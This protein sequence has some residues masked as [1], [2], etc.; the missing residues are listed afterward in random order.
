MKRYL[1]FL[2]LAILTAGVSSGQSRETRDLSGFTG[3]NFGVAGTVIIEQGSTFSVILEGDR[4][5]LEEIQ[6][7]IRGSSLNIR[8][9]NGIW[10]RNTDKI[11]VY[12]TMPE[13]EGLSVSGSGKIIAEAEVKTDDLEMNVSGSGDIVLENLKAESVECGISGSGTIK[14]AGSTQDAELSIS[15]SG[16]LKGHEF[17]T[18]TMDVSISGSGS[19]YAMVEDELEASVSG[20]GDVYYLGDPRIDARISGSGKVRKLK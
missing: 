1:S 5:D 20:S 18:G 4:D 11:T 16:R 14:L 9:D 6:T 12:I 17:R 19:C 2:L 13:I 8:H 7:V 15:G 10:S 3:V